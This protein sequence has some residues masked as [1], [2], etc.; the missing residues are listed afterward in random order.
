MKCSVKG[1]ENAQKYPSTGWCQTHYH[2]YWR[3]GS[4]ELTPKNLRTDL[5]YSGAHGRVKALWGSATRQ[6]C[7]FCKNP[8]DE[9]A[10]DGADESE[11]SGAVFVGSQD[12]PVTYSV[13]PEFYMPLC[14]GCHRHKDRRRWSDSRK[15]CRNGHE[16]TPDNIYTRPSRPGERACK[17]CKRQ[18]AA[19]RYQRKKKGISN[20]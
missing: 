15:T 6:I 20:A 17:T 19:E 3:T 13:W 18:E 10:Y 12:W 7:V 14:S 11:I 1:C 8:A 4:V 9:W 16:L 2:R 5:T